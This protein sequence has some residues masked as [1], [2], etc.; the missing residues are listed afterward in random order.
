MLP[1]ILTKAVIL[2]FAAGM[3]V[4]CGQKI[5]AGHK[6]APVRIGYFAPADKLTGLAVSFVENMKSMQGWCELVPVEQ[7]EGERLLREG[8]LAA[9]LV[10]PENVMEEILT[11]SNRPA[12]LYLS[13]NASPLGLVFEE[14]IAAGTGMLKTAQAEIYATHALAVLYG[15]DGEKLEDMYAE[16]NAYNMGA[17]LNREQYVKTKRLSATGSESV[18][19]YYGSS[20]FTVYLLLSGLFFGRFLKRS[21]LEQT[22]LAKRL[23]ILKGAQLAGRTAVTAGLIFVVL[24]PAM[25]LLFTGGIRQILQTAISVK[26]LLLLCLAVCCTAVWLQLIYSLAGSHRT[27]VLLLGMSA[28]LLGYASG[29]FVPTALLPRAMG[30]AAVFLPSSYIKAAFTVLFTGQEENFAKTAAGLLVCTGILWLLGYLSEAVFTGRD[31]KG[32]QSSLVCRYKKQGGIQYLEKSGNSSQKYPGIAGNGIQGYGLK[33]RLLIFFILT[34]RMLLRKGFLLCLAMTVLLSFMSVRLEKQS[35][36]AVYAAV[37]TPDEAL[38]TLFSEYT[39]LVKFISCDSEEEVKRNVI[40]GKTECGYVLQEDLQ[41]AISQGKGNWTVTAYE[42]ADSTLTYVVNEVLFERIFYAISTEWYAGYIAEN[43][44]FAEV[45]G[46]AGT[47]EL[48]QQAARILTEKMTDGSTFSFERQTLQAAEGMSAGISFYPARFTAAAGIVLC[49]AAGAM[50]ALADIRAG[51]VYKRRK[52]TVVFTVL[53]AVLCGAAAG[54]L[55][56]LFTGYF[57]KY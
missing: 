21:R 12:S 13:D 36:T 55:T 8:E 14:L 32:V 39:G 9:L 34:K 27:A 45:I 38:R 20:F 4:F 51:R 15:T 50:E 7:A 17:F 35:E 5:V 37:Y 28:L 54:F 47:E 6:E 52:E 29:C 22:M 57:M 16:I 33:N 31:L 19:V 48:K 25:L 3:I 26:S 2:A 24:L 18:A 44:N 23:G 1:S 46:T 11:G 10:L 53:G 56:L 43:E 49:G 42:D 41:N 30:K 40:Q